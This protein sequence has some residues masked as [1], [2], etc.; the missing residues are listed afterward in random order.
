MI[1]VSSSAS[2]LVSFIQGAGSLAGRRPDDSF[3]YSF[4]I[5]W[6]FENRGSDR[7]FTGPFANVQGERV[8][9]RRFSIFLIPNS[10]NSHSNTIDQWWRFDG[11][12]WSD[13]TRY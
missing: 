1:D 5:P 3:G 7:H 9:W 11:W 8:D 10:P 4:E 2:R 12:E 6:A 13:C